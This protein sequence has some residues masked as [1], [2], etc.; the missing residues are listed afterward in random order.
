MKIKCICDGKQ[1]FLFNNEPSVR[2]SFRSTEPE[3]S[4]ILAPLTFKVH[5]NPKQA[6]IYELGGEYTLEIS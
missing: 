5:L 6:L 2:L 1:E 4:E 3:G